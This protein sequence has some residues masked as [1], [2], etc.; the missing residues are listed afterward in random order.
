M[1]LQNSKLLGHV[2]YILSAQS[3]PSRVAILYTYIRSAP[4]HATLIRDHP[5]AAGQPNIK[6]GTSVTEKFG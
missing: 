6:V 3:L 4:P 1:K 2:V 5:S